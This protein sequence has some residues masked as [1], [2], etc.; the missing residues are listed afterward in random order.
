METMML[1]EDIS[2]FGFQVK[3]FPNGI[4]KAFDALVALVP[5]GVNRSYYGLSHMTNDNKVVY[6]AAVEEKKSGE[7]EKYNH[8]RYIIRKG[9]Y[10]SV[11]VRNWR[12]KTGSI[13]DVFHS[14]MDEKAIDHTAPCIEWYKNDDEMYCMLK[15]VS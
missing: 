8:T 6:I 3:T 5:E 14:M 2:I 12:Q 1:N 4:D 10:I 7:A 9:K 13:K 11:L 15:L